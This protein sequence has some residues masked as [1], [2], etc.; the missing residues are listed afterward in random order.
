MRDFYTVLGVSKDADA[1]SVKKAYRKLAMQYHPD[2]NPGD[3]AAE[4]RFK[5]AAQAYEVLGNAEKRAQYD[6][7]GHAAFQG[8]GFGG[9]G[10]APF[11]DINDIFSSFG[12][13]FGDM[14]GGGQQR[15]SR[16]RAS[17]G[18]D[19]RYLMDIELEQVLE[20]F[21]KEIE[22]DTED[23][24]HTCNGN[25]ADKGHGPEVCS[26][27]RGTG[28]VVRAQGFF[29]LAT[30]CSACGG[31]G[32]IIKHKC[33]TCRGQGR[34]RVPKKLK[35]KVPAGVRTGT[36]LRISGEGEGG[37]RGGNAGDLY[38][39][40]RVVDHK[41]FERDGDDIVGELK[42]SYLQAIL[43]ATIKTNSLD[44]E[45]EVQIPQGIQSGASVRLSGKGLP[46]I[47]SA[48]KGDLYYRVEVVIPQK[49]AKDEEQWLREI[50]KSKGENVSENSSFSFFKKK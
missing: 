37:Y 18:S 28:Q 12:D 43:G 44:G 5:E 17:R 23:N 4:D 19:L 2:K 14:F 29:S 21:E 7:F 9:Q 39:E 3:K 8:G 26:T 34:V 47:K 30:P 33:K 35:V 20:S 32:Q 15:G 48:Q 38:V 24:C 22:Y 41:K 50:A 49:L 46:S 11:G 31:A 10:G 1:D 42:V 36:R 16:T 27:C 40:I 13:I 6:R 45:V 25:G